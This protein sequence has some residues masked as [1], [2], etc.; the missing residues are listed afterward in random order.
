[1][2]KIKFAVLAVLALFTFGFA[3]AGMAATHTRPAHPRISRHV[4]AQAI[5]PMR[6]SIE[7]MPHYRLIVPQPQLEDYPHTFCCS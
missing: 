5:E 2:L 6:R 3:S 7:P 1:M 4:R